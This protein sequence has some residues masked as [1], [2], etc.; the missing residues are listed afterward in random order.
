MKNFK[1]P[2]FLILITGIITIIVTVA[3][4][5]TL[6]HQS[7]YEIFYNTWDEV[8]CSKK[9]PMQSAC[10]DTIEH[11]IPAAE[12]IQWLWSNIGKPVVIYRIGDEIRFQEDVNKVLVKN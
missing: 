4:A 12:I 1:K 2:E 5:V 3:L 7:K 10:Y 6:E 8:P 9:M 11:S